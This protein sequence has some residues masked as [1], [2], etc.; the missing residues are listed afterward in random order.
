MPCLHYLLRNMD[1]SQNT[2]K[3]QA[4]TYDVLL[5]RSTLSTAYVERTRHDL[6]Q[7]QVTENIKVNI[8]ILLS[9]RTRSFFSHT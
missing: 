2:H 1:L 9:Q 8:L 7:I 6:C 3:L 4:P 5:S